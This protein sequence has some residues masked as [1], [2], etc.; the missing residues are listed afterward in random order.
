MAIQ[1]SDIQSTAWQL[2]LRA[3]G[4]V[5]QGLNDVRQCVQLI[6]TTTQGSDPLR[7]LFGSKLYQYI[8]DPVVSAAPLI[9]AEILDCIGKWEPRITI[10]KLI[11]DIIGYRIE[12]YM[13]AEL[14]DSNE[15]TE[16]AFYIDRQDNLE[17]IPSIGRAFSNG[18]DF[19][20]S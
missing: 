12:F 17:I 15:A 18:F 7:P 9:C 14:V 8:D 5:T 10:K 11:Y 2:S 6:L 16:L 13:F 19:G 3:P 1:I 20:F 4:E